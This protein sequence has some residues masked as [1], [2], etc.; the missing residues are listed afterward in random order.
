MSRESVVFYTSV[1]Y[2]KT[3]ITGNAPDNLERRKVL[4]TIAASTAMVMVTA[5]FSGALGA[6]NAP[7]AV[8]QI[9]KIQSVNQAFPLE[10]KDGSDFDVRKSYGLVRTVFGGTIGRTAE[11]YGISR[12]TI[13]QW[14]NSEG[15]PSLQTR[16]IQRAILL[17]SA[18]KYVQ[19]HLGEHSKEYTLLETSATSLDDILAAANIDLVKLRVCV[20][21]IKKQ[22]VS[23]PLPE[24]SLAE[25]L[26]KKGFFPPEGED[27]LDILI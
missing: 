10:E 14:I 13:Y 24:E 25:R 15:V 27:D 5:D 8:D 11:Y 3:P 4:Q 1:D 20:E 21:E 2:G 19:S 7:I 22:I 12:K 18:A 17:E 26:E 9:S 6:F 16:Q 23:S